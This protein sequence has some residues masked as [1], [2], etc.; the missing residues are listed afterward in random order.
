LGRKK[1]FGKKRIA[2]FHDRRIGD[3]TVRDLR[4]KGHKATIKKLGR[5]NHVITY[6]YKTD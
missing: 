3:K 2:R 5:G 6:Q 4:A 1:R